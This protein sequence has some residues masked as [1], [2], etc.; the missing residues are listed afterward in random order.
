VGNDRQ[1]ALLC[2]IIGQAELADDARFA[3]NPGRVEHRAELIP[4]LAEAFKMRPVEDWVEKL[5][6]AGIPAGP[7]QTMAEILDDPHVAARGMVREVGLEGGEVIR[8]VGPP[9]HLSATPAEVRLPPPTLGAHTDEVLREMLGE[10]EE[11]IAAWREDEV[12]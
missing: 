1:F 3:G 2:A 12:V 9:M 10:T 11:R 4:L 7:I 5:L 6:G 8:L